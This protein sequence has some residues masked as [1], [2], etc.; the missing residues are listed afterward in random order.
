MSPDFTG[1]RVCKLLVWLRGIRQLTDEEDH[2]APHLPPPALPQ[3][4]YVTLSIPAEV[5]A[6]YGKA[7]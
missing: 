6:S 3:N 2:I 7:R 4:S 5:T 1:L